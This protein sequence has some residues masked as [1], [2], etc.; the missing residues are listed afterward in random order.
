MVELIVLVC[1]TS[2]G[3]TKLY[4][5]K[6]EMLSMHVQKVEAGIVLIDNIAVGLSFICH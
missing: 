2:Y 4:L 5:M 6:V 1:M 3:C